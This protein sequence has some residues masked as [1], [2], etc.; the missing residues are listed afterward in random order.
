MSRTI[1]RIALFTMLIGTIAFALNYFYMSIGYTN[2]VVTY[3]EKIN[4]HGV[5]MYKFNF[6]LYFDN[7]VWTFKNLPHVNF[8]FVTY[9]WQN[10]APYSVTQLDVAWNDF[11][12]N[13]GLIGNFFILIINL[14]LLPF[15]LIGYAI[16]IIGAI[17]GIPYF[18]DQTNPMY[19]FINIGKTLCNLQVNYISL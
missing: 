17:A 4:I 2:Q 1:K 6:Y 19:W 9:E 13:L 15:K 16:Q 5:I 12:H 8:N 10:H 11:V 14:L 3:M 7:I 18:A